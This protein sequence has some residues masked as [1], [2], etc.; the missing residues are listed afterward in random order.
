MSQ[1]SLDLAFEELDP[2]FAVSELNA[3]ISRA[4]R[5]AFSDE[6]WVRGEIR[7]FKRSPAG[8]VYFS[9]VEATADGEASVQV[10]LFNRARMV[11]EGQLSRHRMS[12]G[13]GIEVRIRGQVEFYAPRGQVSLRMSAIDHTYT[14]GRLAADRD[15]LLRRLVADGLVERNK[16][17]PLSLAPMRV[18][19]ITS[20]NSAAFHDFVQ[21][22]HGSGFGWQVVLADARVQG[23]EAI[24]QIVQSLTRLVRAR[25]DVICV[26]RGG[27]SKT[28][29]AAFDAEPLARAIAACPIPVITGIGHEVDSSVA[30]LLA[31]RACKTPTACAA[32]LVER[33][34]SYAGRTEMAWGAITE[35]ARLRLRRADEE[36]GRRALRVARDVSNALDHAEQSAVF[37]G[38]RLGREAD[39]VLQESQLGFE[40][41]SA[42]L[43]ALAGRP[44]A[45]A[46]RQLES[47]AAQIGRCAPRAVQSREVQLDGLAARIAS[48][49]PARLLARGW[50]IT[51]NDRGEVVRDPA[52]LLPGDRLITTLEGGHLASIVEEAT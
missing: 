39:L 5:R 4:L 2:T 33:V 18:G 50:S 45:A 6:V 3:E 15:A 20:A 34:T 31:F 21:E 17:R 44:L 28:D 13:D 9:L 8:H 14:L 7:N 11:I 51:R 35:V 25:V 43:G 27:G 48:L 47:L 41:R 38:R 24:G 10:T 49:D 22:L 1:P 23:P 36:L 42:R 52:A 37:S 12:L 29:L 16:A 30:D 46:S 26:V 40:R 19:L 32:L